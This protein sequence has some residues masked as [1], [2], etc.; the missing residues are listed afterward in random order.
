MNDL[1]KL[2]EDLAAPAPPE[3]EVSEATPEPQQTEEATATSSRDAKVS[4]WI[5]QW[6]SNI[7]GNSERKA[8]LISHLDRRGSKARKS[9][10][11]ETE[12]GPLEIADFLKDKLRLLSKK[13]RGES[14]Y[15]WF[16]GV[17]ESNLAP[18]CSSSVIQGL[19]SEA[20][21]PYNL[22]SLEWTTDDLGSGNP[23]QHEGDSLSSCKSKIV[24]QT[25]VWNELD[26]ASQHKFIIHELGHWWD[27]LVGCLSH[28][29][30]HALNEGHIDWGYKTEEDGTGKVVLIESPADYSSRQLRNNAVITSGLYSDLTLLNRIQK[31]F[32]FEGAKERGLDSNDFIDS[33]FVYEPE[34]L[35]AEQK[36]SMS[37]RLSERLMSLDACLD[38]L[39][40]SPAHAER[41]WEGY[42][43]V[44]HEWLRGS[45]MEEKHFNML[46]E[47]KDYLNKINWEEA[48]CDHARAARRKAD[49]MTMLNG[50]PFRFTALLLLNT[51]VGWQRF[52]HWVNSL[53]VNPATQQVSETDNYN[54]EAGESTASSQRKSLVRLAN[55]LDSMGLIVEADEVDSLIRLAESD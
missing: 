17:V 12:W 4:Q 13:R 11:G 23:G 15:N 53:S 28:S 47:A 10:R 37:Y 6:L 20:F 39:P 5:D 38:F 50:A 46:K 54:P 51:D 1:F 26:E 25:E 48:T 30:G 44:S 29:E 35:T 21:D 24:M 34:M 18:Y 22:F 41:A 36:K 14:L 9:I 3:A 31:N 55:T 52:G 2:S 45:A 16:I 33:V 49:E 19:E 43:F 40:T 8:A 7:K 42:A 27:W 32:G